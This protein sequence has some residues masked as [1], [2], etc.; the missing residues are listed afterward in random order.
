LVRQIRLDETPHLPQYGCSP[1]NGVSEPEVDEH[2]T[3][4]VP[5]HQ[6]GNR[7]PTSRPGEEWTAEDVVPWAP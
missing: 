3:C 1:E 7:A 2:S 5:Q 4:L 6:G